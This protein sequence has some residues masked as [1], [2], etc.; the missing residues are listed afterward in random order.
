MPPPPAAPAPPDPLLG[1]TVGGRYRL[2]RVLGEG[3]MGRVYEAEQDV[4][5]TTRKVALKMLLDEYTHDESVV[6]RFERECTLASQLQHPHTVRVYDFGETADKRLYLAM[7]FLV[8]RTLE[9]VIGSGGALPP[10]RVDTILGQVCG[11]V[12]EAHEKGI[13]HRDLKPANIFLTHVSS[14]VDHVKVLDFGIAKHDPPAGGASA[15]KLTRQ[16]TAVGT[17]PYMSPEQFRGS[18]VDA[19]SD[20]YALGIVAYEM[21][22]GRLP[23]HADTSYEWATRHIMAEPEPFDAT[24]VGAAVPQKMRSAVLRALRKKPADRP[25][26]AM[27]FH[28][29]LTLGA[30]MGLSP[31]GT[32]RVADAKA[33]ELRRIAGASSAAPVHSPGSESPKGTAMLSPSA[34][35]QA[36]AVPGTPSPPPAPVPVPPVAPVAAVAA[37]PRVA[38]TVGGLPAEAPRLG[39]GTARDGG[40]EQSVQRAIAAAAPAAVPGHGRAHAVSPYLAQ[41]PRPA[42][43]SSGVGF[44][45]AAFL[46]GGGIALGGFLYSRRDKT[47]DPPSRPTS[48]P[49]AQASATP[50]N[51]PSQRSVQPTSAPPPTLTPP[52]TSPTYPTSRPK[53]PV[54][55]PT[56]SPTGSATAPAGSSTA[57]TPPD[58]CDNAKAF[59]SSGRIVAA[60]AAYRGCRDPQ[61]RAEVKS[62]IDSQALA[63]V[64]RSGCGALVDAEA[65]ASIGATSAKNA[66]PPSCKLQLPMPGTGTPRLPFP[67]PTVIRPR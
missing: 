39:T 63:K 1:T 65:A 10:A 49:T 12:S 25:S 16:G 30:P 53:P 43:R 38:A 13:V 21:L 33:D 46:V 52:P 5:G 26:T 58:Q 34:A 15:K 23:F 14:G 61:K 11:S 6:G 4:G 20:V 19:R 31:T 48:K 55:A 47:S 27:A 50:P 62:V 60:V 45:L 18:N 29:E 54:P 40:I 36:P 9:E 67:I 32:E 42:Q 56:V 44:V 3:G 7:E 22:T 8:G 66:L 37:V 57:P 64:R 41:P 17:P 59:A 28:A 35:S 2:V 51:P 24:P